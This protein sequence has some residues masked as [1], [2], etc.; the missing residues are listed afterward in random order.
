MFSKLLQRYLKFW[1]VRYLKRAKPII[2][3][4]TGSVGK[5]STK[6]AIFEVLRIKFGKDI[7]KSEGNL[8]NESGVPL[9]I[10]G[11]SQAPSYGSNFL[12]WFPIVL[13]MPFKSL[14][15][16]K[17][18]ILVL[19]MAADKPGDI[20]YLTSFVKPNMAVLVNIGPAH[21]EAFG[22]IEKIVQEKTELLRALPAD[23]FAVLN[24]DDEKIRATPYNGQVKTYAIEEK[25]E[26]VA[27]N[28][29]TEIIDYKPLTKFQVIEN[30]HKFAA[31]THTLGRRANV[32]SALAATAAGL[33][34]KLNSQEIIQGLNNIK[35]EKHRLNI[36]RGKNNSIIIDDSYNAN[37][38]SMKAALEVLKDLPR[39]RKIVVLGEMREIGKIAREAHKLIGQYAR[40]V[41]DEVISVGEGGERYQAEKHFTSKQEV[42]GYLLGEIREGDILLIK[43]SRALE[44]W[45]ITEA[46]KV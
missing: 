22:D 19:E 24:F 38:V 3:A 11:Y 37:P 29:T 44:L 12:S 35:P 40:E 46:L 25:A 36:L 32:Y 34:F 18:K 41:A 5:T 17:I 8:N 39:Q 4:I 20:K 7:R 43:A 26:V 42:V 33:I 30:S 10:L 6:N 28:I 21:L 31:Q 2:V 1:A 14:L 13:S 9:A 16:Q 15:S 45:D 27:R 23:G